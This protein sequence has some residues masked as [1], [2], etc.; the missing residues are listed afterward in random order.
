LFAGRIFAGDFAATTETIGH[1][2]DGLETPVKDACVS[3]RLPLDQSDQC[4]EDVLNQILWH[5]TTGSKP[6]P[7]WAVK[8]VDDD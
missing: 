6:Y 7:D 4:P 8:A 2:T 3:A 5:A 1:N